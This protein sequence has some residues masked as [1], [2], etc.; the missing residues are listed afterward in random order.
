[1]PLLPAQEDLPV[2]VPH[3]DSSSSWGLTQLQL[4]LGGVTPPPRIVV[5]SG[6]PRLRYDLGCLLPQT[7]CRP[8]WATALYGPLES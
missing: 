4:G 1:M 3:L 7:L 8:P 2:L 5:W 6:G